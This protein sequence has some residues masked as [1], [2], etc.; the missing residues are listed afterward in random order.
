VGLDQIQ[1]HLNPVEIHA[2]EAVLGKMEDRKY[3][4]PFRRL[5][6]W[7]EELKLG[8]PSKNDDLCAD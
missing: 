8:Y 7:I 5:K 3:F 2:T 1:Q 6:I 4:F